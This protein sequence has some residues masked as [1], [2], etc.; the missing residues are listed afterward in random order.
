MA[1]PRVEDILAAHKWCKQLS[2]NKRVNHESRYPFKD[3]LELSS[4]TW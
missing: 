3:E 2:T 4:T 1:S